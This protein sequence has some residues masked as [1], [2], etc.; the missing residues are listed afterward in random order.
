MA[1]RLRALVALPE[2]MGSISSTY[3]VTQNHLE[4]QIKISGALFWPPQVLHAH[5]EQPYMQAKHSSG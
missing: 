5:D 3:M 1:Q 2:D 4:L